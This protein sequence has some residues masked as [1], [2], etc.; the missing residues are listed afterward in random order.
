MYRQAAEQVSAISGRAGRLLEDA[1]ADALA[2]LDFPYTHHLKL[3]TNNVQERANEEIRRRVKVISAFPSEASMMRLVGAVLLDV[4]DEW[5]DMK[6][7]DAEGL[8]DVR[9]RRG[10]IEPPSPE[11]VEKAKAYVLAAMEEKRRAA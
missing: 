3:R 5:S 7:L 2:Y 1:E 9:R 10:D 11:L 4:N 8:G 6:F